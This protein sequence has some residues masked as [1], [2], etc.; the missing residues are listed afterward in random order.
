M[1]S[2]SHRRNLGSSRSIAPLQKADET[3]SAWPRAAGATPSYSIRLLLMLLLQC[4]ACVN[5]GLTWQC[6]LAG[7]ASLPVHPF[8]SVMEERQQQQPAPRVTMTMG[9]QPS[10]EPSSSGP[11][12]QQLGIPVSEQ[13]AAPPPA[14]LP[15]CQDPSTLSS[16]C[17]L[18]N[19]LSLATATYSD[20]EAVAGL[21]TTADD[22]AASLSSPQ[23][24]APQA[25]AQTLALTSSSAGPALDQG[26]GALVQPRLLTSSTSA[27]MITMVPGAELFDR[28]YGRLR[29]SKS[30]K[31]YYMMMAHS[32]GCQ[33]VSS[34]RSLHQ[35]A[36]K[37]RLHARTKTSSM[38]QVGQC[39][40]EG[41]GGIQEAG[42]AA[43]AALHA[44]VDP[45]AR[46]SP[47]EP[48]A[49]VRP[50]GQ[51]QGDQQASIGKDRLTAPSM[52]VASHPSL[53]LP[54]V[55]GF[56]SET[57]STAPTP[58]EPGQSTHI[59]G[60]HEAR[61]GGSASALPSAAF[62]TSGDLSSANS[63]RQQSTST[64]AAAS[65]SFALCPSTDHASAH[66]LGTLEGDGGPASKPA[67]RPRASCPLPTPPLAMRATGAGSKQ[68]EGLLAAPQPKWPYGSSADGADAAALG[69]S[70]QQAQ[71]EEQLAAAVPSLPL[72]LT[73]VRQPGV[74]SVQVTVKRITNHA[75]Q[76]GL[77]VVQQ[78]VS[79]EARIEALLADLAV[80]E[81][82]STSKNVNVPE[83]MAQ[84]ARRH[85]DVTLLFM[86]I[87]GFTAMSKEVAPETVMVFLNT[88]FALFD[89][90]CDKHG[91]MKV[92]TA[93]DCYIVAGG[94]LDL[95][96][97]KLREQ[98]QGAQE[99][100]FTEVLQEHNAAD[101]A[102]RV[103]AF[104]KDMMAASQLVRTP[105]NGQ[106]V[107]I[108]I[109]LHTGNCV[110]GLVRHPC[111]SL[112]FA[113]ACAPVAVRHVA[114][115]HLR[116]L[117]LVML[118]LQIGQKIPK[119]AVL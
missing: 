61:D 50:A 19:S 57:A 75:G 83:Q 48:L 39:F 66:Y 101:S 11:H 112:A 34:S 90:L 58:L 38:L 63:S 9:A 21:T 111:R 29:G 22:L 31:E 115:L 76:P 53:Q 30:Q 104:A 17:A 14:S 60:C 74:S 10:P 24:L 82:L 118:L 55:P 44:A 105:H 47:P 68:A 110:S 85:K 113:A 1:Y 117:P 13:G 64:W 99:A 81:Y 8:P 96:H 40:V 32:A 27:H 109:G 70:A 37:K 91:V 20:L 43:G 79:A 65:L 46:S 4:M 2:Q 108:R 86:D 54:S 77:L 28:G 97:T 88:L 92:E 12:G 103:M 87:V 106:P 49:A 102:A 114:M 107:V 33:E 41:L 26:L 72:E 119:F 89:A 84:L 80:V 116:L 94:I 15:P 98:Q 35:A 95:P 25:A 69:S 45:A 67:T 100:G 5:G 42:V 73:L 52:T 93:G 78:D 51:E 18:L 71:A 7:V 36:L 56:A 62:P 16:Q 3:S 23:A 6:H 59:L